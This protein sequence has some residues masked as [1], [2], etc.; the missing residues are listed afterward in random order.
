MNRPNSL[1]ALKSA[2]AALKSAL[3]AGVV[4]IAFSASA[5]ADFM[6]ITMPNWTPGHSME[7]TSKLNLDL[8]VAAEERWGR[9][10]I[11]WQDPRSIQD[12]MDRERKIEPLF[13]VKF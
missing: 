4:A 8:N 3:V 10:Q 9:H 12:P 13:V 7:A 1:T 2:P 5:N 6:E 11:K